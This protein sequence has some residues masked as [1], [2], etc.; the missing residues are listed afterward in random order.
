MAM[1]VHIGQHR[2]DGSDDRGNSGDGLGGRGGGVARTLCATPPGADVSA[3][4]SVARHKRAS[5]HGKHLASPLQEV[6]KRGGV[7]A[8]ASGEG[9]TV[10][11]KVGKKQL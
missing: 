7:R 11:G 1:G 3:P 5:H 4:R 9:R 6:Q 10:G 2:G 8:G